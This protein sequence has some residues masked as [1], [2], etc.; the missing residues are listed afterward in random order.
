[1][2]KFRICLSTLAA[3]TALMAP[4]APA[5]AQQKFMTIGTGGVTGVYYAAGGAI[6]RLVNKDRAK[7]GIRCSV[8]STGGSVFNVNTIKAGELDL[9]F[10]QSDV[11][12]NAL[13]GV[14][15]FKD[16]AYTDLR[17]VFSVHPEPFT[18][19]ARKEANIKA[20]TDFK[21]KRFNVGNPGS[22]TRASM[23]ELLGAMGWKLGDFSLASELKADEHGPA[24]CDGKI[25][26]FFYGVGHPS[27]NIQDPTT[28]CGAQL[29]SITGPAVDKLIAD[30][31]YYAKATIP[32]GLY[33]N[34]PNPAQTYGVLATVVTSSKVP[35]DSVY[36]VVKAVFD[37]FDEFKKL[38]PALANLTPEAMVANGNSAPL[39]EGAAKFYKEKGWIK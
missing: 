28:S 20:F 12:F 22:G 35:A 13:K 36:Q 25:D 18:V 16:A 5:Q 39:H 4:M 6:C 11:Q 29:V 10:T 8:E 21:G 33:P 27:A 1:M 14:G 7:H 26:G 38:H 17:A 37:N 9:G 15:Q 32:G 3:A 2:K 24:L 31:P 34:N 23:E 19:L 30:K